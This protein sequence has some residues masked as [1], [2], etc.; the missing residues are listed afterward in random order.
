MK[1]V[2]LILIAI[3]LQNYTMIQLTALKGKFK[4]HYETLKQNF[5][6]I[7]IRKYIQQVPHPV[8]YN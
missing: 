1:N 2:H 7:F 8:S 6:Q 5:H 3:N 4:E